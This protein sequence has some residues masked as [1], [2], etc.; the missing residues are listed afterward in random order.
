[1]KLY[2]RKVSKQRHTENDEHEEHDSKISESSETEEEEKEPPKKRRKSYRE[3][4]N[5]NDNDDYDDDYDG[6]YDDNDMEIRKVKRRKE[7]IRH[8]KEN[9]K[10][11]IKSRPK[12]M[13]RKRKFEISS[14]SPEI[15]R[16][17][18]NSNNSNSNMNFLERLKII[19][20]EAAAVYNDLEVIEESTET[21][22]ANTRRVEI[23]RDYKKW[24]K[25]DTD[26][27]YKFVALWGSDYNKISILT[28][29]SVFQIGKKFKY[30]QK[31]NPERFHDALTRNG[32]FIV[33]KDLFI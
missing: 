21:I 31:K 20:P 8:R 11:N 4:N 15:A 22:L 28:G 33:Y 30:E 7:N 26:E 27:F 12:M 16:Q 17:S 32:E 25:K 2:K 24:Q 1:M 29:R 14:S 19:A 23:T 3:I 9:R 5:H 13:F 18:I 10:E 6:D